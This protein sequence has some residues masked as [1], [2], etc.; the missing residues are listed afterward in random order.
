[1]Q[2]KFRNKTSFPAYIPGSKVKRGLGGQ[3][4]KERG[5]AGKQRFSSMGE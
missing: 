4:S 1:M 2:L 3:G 5:G